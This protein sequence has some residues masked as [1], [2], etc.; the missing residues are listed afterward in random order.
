MFGEREKTTLLAYVP[1]KC[2]IQQA[3]LSTARKTCKGYVSS[4]M[5]SLLSLENLKNIHS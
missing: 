1:E 4:G 3:L 5:K 2:Y